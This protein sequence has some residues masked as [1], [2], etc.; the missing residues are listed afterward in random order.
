[1]ER[2][3]KEQIACSKSGP[4]QRIS[5][6]PYLSASPYYHWVQGRIDFIYLD[7]SSGAFPSDQLEWFDC[8]LERAHNNDGISTVVVGMH[9]ALPSCRA[10]DHAMCDDGIKDPA[11]K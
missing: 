3:D 8:I 2:K 10:S 9:E 11:K 1:M 5:G 4:C 7:N 6:Q